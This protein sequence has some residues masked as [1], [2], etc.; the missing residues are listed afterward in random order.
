MVLKGNIAPD[1][2]VVKV[3]GHTMTN[4]QGPARVSDSEEAAFAA[5]EQGRIKAGDVVVIRDEGPQGG[6]GMREMLAVL[7]ALVGVGLGESVGLF[8]DGRFSGATRGRDGRSRRSRG[9]DRRTDRGG[10]RG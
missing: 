9:G 7:A 10:T 3:A 6:P 1:G 2:C 8:T 4:H 5:V